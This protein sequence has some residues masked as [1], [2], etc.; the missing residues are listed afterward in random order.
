[1]HADHA[2]GCEDP[3]TETHGRSRLGRVRQ[4]LPGHDDIVGGDA[5]VPHERYRCSVCVALAV[6]ALEAPR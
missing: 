2:A 4:V 5:L 6:G 1:M 3:I